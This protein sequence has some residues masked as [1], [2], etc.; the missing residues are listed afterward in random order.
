MKTW[1]LLLLLVLPL[2][3]AEFGG[4]HYGAYPRPLHEWNFQSNTASQRGGSTATFTRAT[5]GSQITYSSGNP[6]V[7]ADVASGTAQLS[8]NDDY[9]VLGGVFTMP[10]AVNTRGVLLGGTLLYSALHST[11]LDN[12]AWSQ[13]GTAKGAANNGS[14]SDPFGALTLDEVVDDD[15][16]VAEY[17]YQDVTINDDG[18][19]HTASG[20]VYCGSSHSV[21]LQL[22]LTG[23]TPVTTTTTKTCSTTL[24][25]VFATA[26][27]NTTGN[28][29]AQVRVYATTTTASETGTTLWGYV[30]VLE[31]SSYPSL[32]EEDTGAAAVTV[33][34][35]DLTYSSVTHNA[36]GT[37][38][39]WFY[40]HHSDDTAS[41]D[42][43]LWEWNGTDKFQLYIQQDRT[44]RFT[45][46]GTLTTNNFNLVT[47]TT[48][49]DFAW[50]HVC[51][52][53][54]QPTSQ[55]SIFLNGVEASYSD[56]A[57]AFD[58][59]GVY[60]TTF[61]IGSVVGRLDGER[62]AAFVQYWQGREFDDPQAARAYRRTK[63]LGG[64]SAW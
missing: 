9:S 20:W 48:I 16:G 29:T 38:C 46:A 4:A 28:T 15:A 31:G 54:N 57:D 24:T 41:T 45:S 59:G 39:G 47:S 7:Y 64:F 26:T 62:I 10:G 61:Q 34:E 2:L 58:D 6:G 51:A 13:N 5:T 33:N 19:K 8:V 17:V 21:V 35:D 23:G 56:G 11:A 22:A 49:D 43:G 27:N 30:Q 14:I 1:A 40:L 18:S 36:I 50:T 25:K 60:G 42:T 32:R 3:F 37:V 53:W 12:A 52:S 44:L 63:T 55:Q